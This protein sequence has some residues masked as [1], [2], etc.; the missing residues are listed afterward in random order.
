M[1]E[2]EVVRLLDEVQELQVLL[3]GVFGLSE[4]SSAGPALIH[5]DHLLQG[6]G[7]GH[8]SVSVSVSVGSLQDVGSA[9]ILLIHHVVDVACCGQGAQIGSVGYSFEKLNSE[10]SDCSQSVS[11]SSDTTRMHALTHQASSFLRTCSYHLDGWHSKHVDDSA[12]LVVLVGSPKQGLPSVH[13][14]HHTA[15]RPHVDLLGVRQA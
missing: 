15:Q 1:R 11:H 9:A 10:D 12:E 14:H 5:A 6:P 8:L 2:R 3:R 4:M 13:L 7:L